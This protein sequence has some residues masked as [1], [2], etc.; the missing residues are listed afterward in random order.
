MIDTINEKE[1]PREDPIVGETKIIE[2]TK[3]I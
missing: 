3:D 2:E 1:V